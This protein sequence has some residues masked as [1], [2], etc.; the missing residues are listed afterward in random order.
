MRKFT[1]IWLA[2]LISSIG[3][4]MG[5]FAITLWVWELTGSATSLALTGF[6]YQLPRIITAIFAGIVVDRFSRKYL[7]ILSEAAVVVSTLMLLVLHL[8]GQLEIWHLYLAASINGGFG[9]FGGLA[10]RA[11]I[12]LLVESKNYTRAN[13]MDTATR[14][15]CILIAPALAGILYPI[16]GL[17]GIFSIKLATFA[18][19]ITTLALLKIP[20]PV[21]EQGK[22]EEKKE[23]LLNR[24]T[25]FW[26]EVTF[27]IRYLWQSPGLRSLL[28]VTTIFQL[29]RRVSNTVYDPMILARTDS[30]SQALAAVSTLAGIGGITGAILVSVWGGFRSNVRG[31]LVGFSLIGLAKVVFGLGQSLSV[32]LTAQFCSSINFPLI[33]S[34]ETALWMAG[35]PAKFQ[36]RVFAA[37]FLVYDLISM[38]VAL[39]A[40]V[41][42][43]RVFEPAMK[44]SSL[45]Q[46]LFAPIFGTG[47]G[48]GIALLYVFSASVML[49]AGIFGF[50]M[51]QLYSIEKD[52]DT[53]Q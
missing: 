25:S 18:I 22:M 31:M 34:S 29:A 2:H 42:S 11:S 6:F 32:W 35:T 37:H 47:A 28:I 20:Q 8:T 51:S 14:Y 24:L 7:M 1:L 45:L 5:D 41:L 17:G 38:P 46:Y 48:A 16:I 50:R 10:Y 36:G 53:D 27:G 39:L 13:S 15:S 12:T 3:T 43:D 30:S 19:P 21:L 49:L 9:K 23:S 26:S 52:F 33:E 40:G 44:S 4:R